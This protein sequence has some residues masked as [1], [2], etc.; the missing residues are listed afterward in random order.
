MTETFDKF[1]FM[2]QLRGVSM[3]PHD[4]RVLITLLTYADRHGGNAFPSISTLTADCQMNEKTV[5]A[6]LQRLEKLHLT[7]CVK[8]GG[9]G[10]GRTTAWQIESVPTGLGRDRETPPSTGGFGEEETAR[11]EGGFNP[12]ANHVANGLLQPENP[13]RDDQ[14]T[15]RGTP[16]NPPSDDRKIPRAV[17]DNQGMTNVSEQGGP[18]GCA[19]AHAS[20]AR[21]P[22]TPPTFD[23]ADPNAFDPDALRP[24]GTCEEHPVP[25]IENC[26]PCKV[27]R[28]RAEYHDEQVR[29]WGEWFFGQED[30]AL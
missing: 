30:E 5:A 27:A 28:G 13:P 18:G 4:F 16:G 22:S 25:V 15:P 26:I 3:R 19:D 21:P 2:E 23:P 14:E 6:A 20:E 24:R 1:R 11:E 9:G 10:R 29:R 8:R 7:R 17:G 12:P